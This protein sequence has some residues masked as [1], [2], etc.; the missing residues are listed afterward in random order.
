MVWHAAMET[1]DK[2][3]LMFQ[4]YRFWALILVGFGSWISSGCIAGV[5]HHHISSTFEHEGDRGQATG[6]VQGVDLGVVADFRYLRLAFPF[7]G[8]RREMS[9]SGERGSAFSISEVV[10]MRT[11]RLDVPLYSLRDFSEE[12]SESR[13]P[14]RMKRRRSLEIWASGSV[15]AQPIHPFTASLGLVYYNYGSFAFRF[16]AGMSMQPYEGI[17]RAIGSD[18]GEQFRRR[19]GYVPGLVGG[20]EVTLAAGEYALEM[21]RFIMDYDRRSRSWTDGR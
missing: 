20:I 5:Q 7:E 8:Q 16:Y 19:E 9:F 10:E 4:T 18:G 1:F 6:Y 14:G 13:Y 11:L 2:E 15:G 17:D 3:P 21:V 12:P